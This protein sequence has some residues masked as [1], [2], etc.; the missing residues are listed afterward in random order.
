M[1]INKKGIIMTVIGGVVAA[2][3]IGVLVKKN[4]DAEADEA[5]FVPAEAYE[6]DCDVEVTESEA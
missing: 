4:K 3:G 5:D 2:L 1:A 6:S